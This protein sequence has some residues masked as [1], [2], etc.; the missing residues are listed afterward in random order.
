MASVTSAMPAGAL[1]GVGDPH[2]GRVDVDAVGDQP[3]PQPPVRQ[4]GPRRARLPV[5]E[6]AHGVEEVGTEREAGVRRAHDLVVRRLGV[7]GAGHRSRSGDQLDRVERARQLGSERHHAHV[8]R[9]EQLPQRAEVDRAE[10][11]RVVRAAAGRCEERA[12]EVHA[13]D[14]RARRAGGPFNRV[15]QTRVAVQRPR[16]RRRQV[17]RHPGARQR[18]AD[19]LE[20]AWIDAHVRAEGAVDLEVDEAGRDHPGDGAVPGGEVA[21]A[22][23]GDDLLHPARADD[24]A[25]APPALGQQHVADEGVLRAHW[26]IWAGE[27]MDSNVPVRARDVLVR[28]APGGT[29]RAPPAA[30]QAGR[31]VSRATERARASRSEPGITSRLILPPAKG[32]R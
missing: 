21:V 11:G 6:R 20:R 4:Q 14:A 3:R 17:G 26:R 18:A 29:V 7:A 1:G 32:V 15:E 30:R 16:D 24:Q 27:T 10:V 12:L 2:G 22:R 23:V 19:R 28:G 9:A 25:G 8:P 5:P 31:A 13:E